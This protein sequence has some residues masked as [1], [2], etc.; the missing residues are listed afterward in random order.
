MRVWDSSRSEK[1]VT[2][3]GKNSLKQK[4]HQIAQREGIHYSAALAR[5]SSAQDCEP[6]QTECGN[7]LPDAPSFRKL[8]AEV[9][10]FRRLVEQRSPIETLAKRLAQQRSPYDEVMKKLVE[11]RSPIETLA[12]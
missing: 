8:T 10:L 3:R 12:M 2:K 1:A 7:P 6:H 4:A 5:L 9:S 11:Q